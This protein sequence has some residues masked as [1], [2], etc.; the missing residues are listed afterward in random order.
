MGLGAATFKSPLPPS[1]R[2]PT[3]FLSSFLDGVYC[4]NIAPPPLQRTHRLLGFFLSRLPFW[5]KHVIPNKLR[6]R[7]N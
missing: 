1:I 2:L 3:L 6:L 7:S 4:A 5:L